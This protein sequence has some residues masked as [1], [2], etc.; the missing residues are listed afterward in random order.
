MNI[1]NH[2]WD[3]FHYKYAPPISEKSV[4]SRSSPRN[5]KVTV[6]FKSNSCVIFEHN[7]FI[8]QQTRGMNLYIY[9]NIQLQYKSQLPVTKLMSS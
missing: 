4:V 5:R 7:S 9:K 2:Q 1:E 3:I 8:H 6:F